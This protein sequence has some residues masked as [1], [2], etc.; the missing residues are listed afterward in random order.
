MSRWLFGWSGNYI[1]LGLSSCLFL[2]CI[3][4]K[5]FTDLVPEM[6][7]IKFLSSFPTKSQPH[8][9]GGRNVVGYLILWERGYVVGGVVRYVVGC[10][11]ECVVEFAVGCTVG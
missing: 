7:W 10:V 5:Y 1:P 4:T 6:Y 8:K 9:L 2:I 3:R 11:V